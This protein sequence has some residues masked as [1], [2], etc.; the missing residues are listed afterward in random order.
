MT[1]DIRELLC[2]SLIFQ[3]DTERTEEGTDN[4]EY[5]TDTC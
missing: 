1:L 2:N 5:P 4:C 3:Q